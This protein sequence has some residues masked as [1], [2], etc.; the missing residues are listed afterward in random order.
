LL[1]FTTDAKFHDKRKE[2]L[3]GLWNENFWYGYGGHFIFHKNG[4]R[5][6]A[7]A[8]LAGL[9]RSFVAYK[10]T[11]Q[12]IVFLLPLQY[13]FKKTAWYLGFAKAH[14]DGYGHA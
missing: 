12:T 9:R 13:T 10:L 14:L 11:Q 7:S 6:H 2:T 8:L 3:K 4:K 1:Y 5:V